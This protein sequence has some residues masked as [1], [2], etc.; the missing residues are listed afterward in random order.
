MDEFKPQEVAT[1]RRH[2]KRFTLDDRKVIEEMFRHGFSKAAISRKIRFC[3]DS[4]KTEAKRCPAGLYSAEEAQKDYDKKQAKR[5]LDLRRS[6]L[7]EEEKKE[8]YNLFIAGWSL[9]RIAEKFNIGTTRIYNVLEKTDACI[10]PPKRLVS[11]K[12][13]RY[14]SKPKL[15]VPSRRKMIETV[16][17][18]SSDINH[19]VEALEEQIKILFEVVNSR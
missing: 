13:V 10:E 19:R 4:I 11:K 18:K 9:R 3:I 14:L 12:G 6:A 7:T 2:A 1:L 15:I 8:I 16:A 17:A 5:Y